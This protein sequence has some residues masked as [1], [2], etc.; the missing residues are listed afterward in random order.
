MSAEEIQVELS[1]FYF[2]LTAST[3][4]ASLF[5]LSQIVD[6][7]HLLMGFDYPMMPSHTIRPA[8]DKFVEYDWFDQGQKERIARG[9][10]ANL[11]PSQ[12]R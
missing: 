8:I 12:T 5:A 1:K 3:G 4:P 6:P 2:D 11:L 7:S 9:N 10:A